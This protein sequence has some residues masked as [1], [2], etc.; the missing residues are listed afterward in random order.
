MSVI[1]DLPDLRPSL[2]L[3]F[4]NSRRLYPLIQHS[5]ASTA[6]C[7]GPDGLLRR[8]PANVPRI[9]YDPESGECL[10]LLIEES[11]SNLLLQS[12]DFTQAAWVKNRATIAAK[13]TLGPD[14]VSMAD[15][16]VSNEELAVEHYVAQANVVPSFAAGDKFCLSAFVKAGA[17]TKFALRFRR[18]LNPAVYITGFFDLV[19][20]A[21]NV[22]GASGGA[23]L[24]LTRKALPN[25]WH[26]CG[27]EY[28]AGAADGADSMSVYAYPA[29]QMN[30][31]Q[32]D[33]TGQADIYLFGMQCTKRQ[34][35]S[36][37]IPTTTAAATRAADA[38]Y[39]TAASLGFT[40]SRGALVVE[41]RFSQRYRASAPIFA[42]PA[43]TLQ[44][45]NC[46]VAYGSSANGS[47]L[48][49]ASAYIKKDDVTHLG[50]M[51]GAAPRAVWNKHGIAM[52]SGAFMAAFNGTVSAASQ[53]E[54]P[55]ISYLGLG[56]QFTGHIRRIAYYGAALTAAELG[57]LT[58]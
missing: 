58:A 17:K 26:W 2:L 4:A 9:D 32:Y 48:G 36:S 21:T 35:P 37:Y 42:G 11:E 8:V 25:G 39:I 3:D 14:G 46:V 41:S 1:A 52:N 31:A 24:T 40:G 13:S 5:R 51:F 30:G 55:A 28:V 29:E 7:Y 45:A 49:L 50:A 20:G 43:T 27:I 12:E 16:I 10:G 19:T 6:T 33:G 18:T 47:E 22:T 44:S 15:A 34:Y 54:L 57:R 56:Y 23:T 38:A 53:G